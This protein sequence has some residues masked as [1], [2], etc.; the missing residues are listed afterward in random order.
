MTGVRIGTRLLS[1]DAP[2]L[3]IAELAWAHDGSP[4]K[5]A[6]IAEAARA[7]GAEAFSIHITSMPDYMVRQY[8]AEGS[9]SAGK[10]AESVYLYLERL[11]PSPADVR[12]LCAR[13]RSLGMSLVLM[14]NDLPSLALA[15]EIGPD[16]LVLAPACLEE[17]EFVRALAAAGSPV[18]LRVGGA[19]EKEI[20][21]AIGWLGG[22]SRQDL[23]LLHGLQTY[24]T[25]I[26][27]AHLR[28]IPALRE[29][30][31]RPVGLADHIDGGDDL[32]L[33][34][35]LLARAMG[36]VVFEKHITW[37]RAERGE[38]FEAALDPGRFAA[39]VRNLRAAEAALGAPGLP[40]E[41]PATERYR[42]V[43]R[44]RVVAA[45]AIPAGKVIGP[46]DL[47]CRRSPSGAS[48][49]DRARLVGRRARAEI[50][51]EA[52][53]TADLLE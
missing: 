16:A 52:P 36:A 39:F 12:T 13:V 53:I 23:L 31:G 35:P 33:S 49:V 9:V 22:E 46:E 32:A 34:I 48:P 43:S 28:A 6:R 7:A 14:P 50:P 37:N 40:R 17:E 11:N 30:F 41:T 18:I 10:P 44:K 8:A 38:D 3:V 51:A 42:A 26:E 21:R 47:A 4:E 45:R 24:P 20:E 29:R 19:T 15:R 2:A 1:D 25:P 5:A 27:E